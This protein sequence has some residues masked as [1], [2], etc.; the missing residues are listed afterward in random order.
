MTYDAHDGYVLLF[1]V[2]G[3]LPETW[4]FVRGAWTNLTPPSVTSSNSPSE[5]TGA[6]MTYDAS[7][8]Y[9]VLFGGDA[10]KSF[11]SDTWK[12]VDG[13]WTNISATA[14]SPPPCRFDA[15]MTDD[16]TDGYVLL[17]G[18]DGKHPGGCGPSIG[19]LTVS[20][21]W[22]FTGGRWTELHPATSPPASW[23]A[24]I[25]Y[26][27]LDGCVVLFGGISTTDMALQQTWKYTS[28]DW[29]LISSPTF[30]PTSPPARF[31]ASMAYDG[32]DGYV[33][34]YSG[35]SEPQH[36]AP[37]LG[38]VWTFRDS[39]WVNLTQNPAPSARYSMAMTWDQKDEFVLLFGG[40][41][42]SGPLADT[43]KFAEGVWL[44]LTPPQSPPA[45]Y[46]ASMNYDGN[47]KD[48]YVVL[49]GGIGKSGVL[50]DTWSF[51]RGE[52][53]N[54]TPAPVNGT[55]S[56]GG[57]YDAA[58]AYD[59]GT[60]AGSVLLFGGQDGAGALSDT[61]LYQNGSWTPDDASPSPSPRA[62]AS[63]AY[64]AATGT[65]YLLLFG[66]IDGSTVL[67]DTWEYT[68]EGKWVVVQTATSPSPRYGSGLVYD[69]AD[70]Y[71]LLFGGVNGE[72]V[73]GDT[74]EYQHG[75]W[76]EVS[77]PNSPTGRFGAGFAY[78]SSNSFALLFG[79]SSSPVANSSVR[80]DTW[81]FSTGAWMDISVENNQLPSV[82]SA[83]GSS[84]QSAETLAIIFALA[85]G[86]AAGL[87]AAVLWVR[88]RPAT[89]AVAGERTSQ[90]LPP[91]PPSSYPSVSKTEG[92]ET[93]REP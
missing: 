42:T 86:L 54:L 63:I 11:L 18:G 9:V 29:S 77:P 20:D 1:R 72:S 8:G 88:G 15:A 73:L 12:F 58:M 32:G 80:N 36:A 68:G 71:A 34:L 37:I 90:A 21:S 35:L 40:W 44:Q 69:R 6:S 93:S 43:W 51:V 76:Q 87:I 25:S 60:N 89:P 79:G 2:D 74:W 28:G 82:P 52:W 84:P 55:N 70:A 26:D 27:A 16:A 50:R 83:P 67:G 31:S 56:P 46:D 91:R 59:S 49:F 45:R 39:T 17:F 62:D 57:R 24:S 75:T 3:Q 85:G 38:D 14:G 30:P 10:Q 65:D 22:S 33:L 78:D 13:E 53:T 66:G 47:I 5:R 23:S 48:Q 92:S 4:S 64:D 61:W 41:G 81:G 19:N 7:D